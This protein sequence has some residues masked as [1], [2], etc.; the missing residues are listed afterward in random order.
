MC[1]TD[2]YISKYRV[3]GKFVRFMKKLFWEKKLRHVIERAEHERFIKKI[4][5]L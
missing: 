2:E 1:E 3:I 4:S 5:G